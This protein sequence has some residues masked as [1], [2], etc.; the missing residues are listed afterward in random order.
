MNLSMMRGLVDRYIKIDINYAAGGNLG[1]L[2]AEEAW[3]TIED[4]VQCNKQW[5]NPTST[6]SDQ[7]IANLK[8]Q[9]V[10]NEVVRV[11]IPKCMSWLDAY[12]EPIG[13]MEDKVD[14]PS[15]QVLPSFEVYTPPVTYPKEVNE[16]LGILMEVEPLDN[17]KL[18]NLGLNTCS[19]DLFPN[20][21][22][23][24]SVDEPEPQP[25]PN[26]PFLDVNLGDKRG[27]DPPINPY[28]PGSFRMKAISLAAEAKREEEK[29]KGVNPENAT[30]NPDIVPFED[31]EEEEEEESE[32]DED[33]FEPGARPPFSQQ[34]QPLQSSQNSARS[35]RD[36]PSGGGS[37]TMGQD[38]HDD[39]TQPGGENNF[40]NS[41]IESEDEAPRRS[42]HREGKKK[43]RSLEGDAATT[44]DDKIVD[45]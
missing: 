10:E 13:D 12:D 20:S 2:S 4:C 16:T 8:A 34:Q 15:P 14:N 6:I 25:L 41:E 5:K 21:R 30:E 27:T 7:T 3:E 32:E 23:F 9:L 39:E 18:E 35:K 44:F 40:K 24:P 45:D 28:S 37:Q 29:A 26:L 38:R 1:R 42:R 33:S 31:N 22:E 19:H 36:Q 43:R 11:M 17:M